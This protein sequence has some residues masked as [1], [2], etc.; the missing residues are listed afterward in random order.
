MPSY[1]LQLLLDSQVIGSETFSAPDD[2][3]AIKRVI[4]YTSRHDL[5]LTTSSRIVAERRE[6]FWSLEPRDYRRQKFQN[7]Q[8]PG[9]I[10]FQQKAL[11]KWDR[12]RKGRSRPSLRA[13][14]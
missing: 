11:P 8:T 14:Y 9:Q 2:C 4:G 7:V 13:F 5:N 1:T 3:K 6:G 10:S 12:P